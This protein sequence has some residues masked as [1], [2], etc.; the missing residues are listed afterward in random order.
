MAGN[1]AHGALPG[2]VYFRPRAKIGNG[3]TLPAAV[4]LF[5]ERLNKLK[6]LFRAFFGPN[7]LRV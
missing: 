4:E 7:N 1:V 6:R 5:A 2:R 3:Y